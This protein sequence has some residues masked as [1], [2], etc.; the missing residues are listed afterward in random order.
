VVSEIGIPNLSGGLPVTW[1]IPGVGLTGY[2]GFGDS[3]E[4]PY[5][6]NNGSLQFIDNLSWIKGKHTFRF[7]GEYMRQTYNQ[8]GNQFARGAFTFQGNAT[9]SPT[10]S[11]GDSFAEFLLGTLYQSDVAVAVATAD[12]QRSL[13]H[14]WFDDTW[15][16]TPKLTLALGLVRDDYRYF[17][18]GLVLVAAVAAC[19]DLATVPYSAMLR[20]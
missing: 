8:V 6:N 18:I 5:V 2:S 15:K 9:L 1:G 14:V 11:G 17:A 4:G 3:S 12:F 19:N 13:K 16:I 7:G 10:L 20:Q